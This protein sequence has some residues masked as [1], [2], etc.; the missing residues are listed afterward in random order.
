MHLPA[1]LANIHRGYTV[2]L[3]KG[4]NGQNGMHLGISHFR[5]SPHNIKEGCAEYHPEMPMDFG[6]RVQRVSENAFEGKREVIT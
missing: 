1:G 5:D 3:V 4:P 6:G 2:Y